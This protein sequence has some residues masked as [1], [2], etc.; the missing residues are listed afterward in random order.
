[1][2]KIS[3]YPNE[4]NLAFKELKVLVHLCHT[5]ITKTSGISCACI[6]Q[7]IFRLIFENKSWF[8]TL[9]SKK[10]LDVPAKDTVYR[11]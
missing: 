8:R 2:T 11:S 3:N 1:M 9:K 10:T 7:L 6:F 4:V 5:G